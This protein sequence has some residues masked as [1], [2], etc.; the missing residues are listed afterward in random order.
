MSATPWDNILNNYPAMNTFVIII[1]LFGMAFAFA[2]MFKFNDIL[3]I[4]C[5]FAILLIFLVG[6]GALSAVYGAGAFILLSLIAYIVYEG[7]EN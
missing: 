6:Y 1:I 7:S 4:L 3:V 2:L 5:M